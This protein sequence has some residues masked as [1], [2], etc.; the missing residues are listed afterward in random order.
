M[1]MMII[2]S[3]ETRSLLL[4]ISLPHGLAVELLPA[5]LEDGFEVFLGQVRLL[6]GTVHLG[7]IFSTLDLL[8]SVLSW[9]G[10]LLLSLLFHHWL[11]LLVL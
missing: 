8:Q 5:H 1:M 7:V 9:L 6:L 3:K 4:G 10:T 2:F 11:G